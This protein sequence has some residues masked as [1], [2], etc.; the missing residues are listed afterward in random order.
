MT[1]YDAQCYITIT[2]SHVAAYSGPIWCGWV[3][4]VQKGSCVLTSISLSLR[5]LLGEEYID[6]V[7]RARH[8]LT[9]TPVADLVALADEQVEFWPEDVARR[10]RD[11][12]ERTGTNLV[13]GLA[14]PADGAGTQAFQRAQNHAAAPI[15]GLGVCRIGQDGR[16]YLAAKSEHY[17]A[18]LGHGFPGYRLIDLARRLG[19]P[20]ATHN[21][22]RGQVTRL[23]EEALV[24]AAAPGLA[25]AADGTPGLH[26]LTR[27]I[28][29]ET[30]SLAA[31]AALKLMLNR[32]YSADGGEAAL[33]G[34]TPVFLVMADAVGGP[35]ANYH[36]TTVAAQLLRGLWP[37]LLRRLDAAGI[38]RVVPVPPNDS[39]AFLEALLRYNAGDY[40]VAGFCHEI[41]LM[42]YGGLRL[43]EDYLREV[44]AACHQAGVPV[45]C[46]EIQSGAWCGEL[47]LFRRYGLR[48]DLVAVGKGFPGGEYPA[49]KILVTAELD[50]LSQFGALV[51]NGQEEL[52]SLAYLVTMTFVSANAAHIE[53]VGAYLQHRLRELVTSFPV[54]AGVT[55]DGLMAGLQFHEGAVAVEFCGRLERE[56]GID[57]SVQAYKPSAPP[58][59]LMK[60]P[61]ITEVE[62]VDVL[63][64]RMERVLSTLGE[65]AR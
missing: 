53:D 33:A 58:V 3:S 26:A 6:A 60:L 36:G 29:L 15:G 39:R 1:E 24:A 31:E 49:S 46:D 42:N 11:L 30:G 34:R 21:N 2:N 61:V 43:E 40:A 37:E 19:I 32:F 8:A 62:I 52:A 7:V 27:V 20:N 5:D 25:P 55:G 64:D 17:Q 9:G 45:F 4:V 38:V 54:L 44:Y 65:V 22:T 56:H 14:H 35:A 13:A 10:S 23:A 18:S 48:P 12:A 28:N 51:T 50:A 57:T 47:F 16:I 63:I 59:A 41:V